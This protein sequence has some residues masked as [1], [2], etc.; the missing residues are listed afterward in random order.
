MENEKDE[1]LGKDFERYDAGKG[2]DGPCFCDV[3]VTDDVRNK[4][5]AEVIH[6]LFPILIASEL[7]I[8]RL[9]MS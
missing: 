3:R 7:E 4:V 2:S 5:L 1:K 9:S 6:F 8:N